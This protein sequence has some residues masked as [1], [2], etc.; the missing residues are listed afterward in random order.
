VTWVAIWT[1]VG[2]S[3]TGTAYAARNRLRVPQR[4]V[5]AAWPYFYGFAD[6][7][8]ALDLGRHST[9][10]AKRRAVAVL[11]P[12][13]RWVK[14]TVSLDALNVARG[15]VDVKVWCDTALIL[16][17]PVGT[18]EPITRYVPVRDG[19]TRMLVET[20]VSG[21][22]RP[23]DYGFKDTRELGLRVEWDFVDAPPAG[24][25]GASD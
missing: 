19:Q 2:V 9:V 7:E 3:A 1:I 4:G 13:T 15:P 20:W 12:T 16:D 5:T 8:P 23:A 18:V 6:M 25:N 22:V 14:L 17:T 24:T 11:A 21:S 10:W